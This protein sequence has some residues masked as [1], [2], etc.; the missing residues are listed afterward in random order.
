MPYLSTPLQRSGGSTPASGGSKR[1]RSSSSSSA[2]LAACASVST[3]SSF[4]LGAAPF[5]G[6]HT[7]DASGRARS[8]AHSVLGLGRGL[9]KDLCR[10]GKTGISQPRKRI[11]G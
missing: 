10:Y 3:A 11:K 5:F 2:L 8:T 1:S 9:G 4:S 6:R 7:R